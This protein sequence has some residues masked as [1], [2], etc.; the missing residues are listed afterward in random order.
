[1]LDGKH[2]GPERTVEVRRDE[3]NSL[4]ISIV[5]G[6]VDLSW[7][8]SSVTGIFIKNVLSESPAGKGGHLKTGDRIL[9]VEGIDLRGATH[10]KAVEVIKKTGNPVTFVVQ[11]L[12]QWTPANSA[13]P[14]RDVSR[15]GT[16][17]PS[18]ITPAR[19]PT[20]ELIQ[21][22][23]PLREVGSQ[24][25]PRPRL[26]ESRLPAA[27][28]IPETS[29]PIHES[30]PEPV[31]FVPESPIP[32]PED[33]DSLVSPYYYY[34]RAAL[35]HWHVRAQRTKE[36]QPVIEADED[37][38]DQEN[39]TSSS[40]GSTASQRILQLKHF[41]PN[42][43][44]VTRRT[45]PNG[46]KMDTP[47]SDSPPADTPPSDGP[48]AE[49]SLHGEYPTP[50]SATDEAPPSESFMMEL[51]CEPILIECEAIETVRTYPHTNGL[52]YG[53]SVQSEPMQNNS[54]LNMIQCKNN[55]DV[56]L[57]SNIIQTQIILDDLPVVHSLNEAEV[58]D[59]AYDWRKDPH[60]YQDPGWW[61]VGGSVSEHLA[62]QVPTQPVSPYDSPALSPT[63]TPTVDQVRL[64]PS[65]P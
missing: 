2:W 38:S 30:C 25:P 61:C 29:T 8:G 26:Q 54:E 24:R 11:S 5:G 62:A 42:Y 51:S 23:T 55:V 39:S 32:E 60:L 33:P 13:P 43:G 4:G 27:P 37:S 6:K 52:V 20:P 34:A 50:G 14:S 46:S 44:G 9:E 53:N 41:C 65:I 47:P 63:N 57:G 40:S 1:M 7:S 48:P 49:E 3:K 31:R 59:Y 16:R 28:A 56:D 10:E 21:A 12:V 36:N 22:R 18:S 58:G 19:T 17:Y 64:P 45:R 15:L 35:A